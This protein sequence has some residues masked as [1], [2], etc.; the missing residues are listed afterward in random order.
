MD[1]SLPLAGIRFSISGSAG[2]VTS[3]PVDRDLLRRCH[4][5]VYRLT[6]AILRSGGEIVA[7]VGDE[8]R[9]DAAAPETAKIFYWSELEA[10]AEHLPMQATTHAGRYLL[11]AVVSEDP[12]KIRIPQH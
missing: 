6:L 8:P 10:I 2:D 3:H 1:A 11:H 5:F 12:A 7:F 4:T 9:L